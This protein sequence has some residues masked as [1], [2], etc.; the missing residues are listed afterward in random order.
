MQH[1]DYK[2]LLLVQSKALRGLFS[3]IRDK[4]TTPMKFASYADRIHR[5]VYPIFVGE[6]GKNDI[7]GYTVTQI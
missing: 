3:V 7:G 1:P 4:S 2:N 6:A 5:C